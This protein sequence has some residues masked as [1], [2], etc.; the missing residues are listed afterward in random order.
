MDYQIQCKINFIIFI[1]CLT[2]TSF[3]QTP[4]LDKSYDNLKWND[5]VVRVEQNFPVHF[6]Y[7][8]DSVFNFKIQINAP[9]E[10]LDIVLENNLSNK[11]M[12]V[13]KDKN[14]NIFITQNSPISFKL[15]SSFFNSQELKSNVKDSIITKNETQYL[16]TKNEIGTSIIYVGTAKNG[17]YKTEATMSGYVTNK[18]NGT[19]V[20]GAIL[21]IEELKTGTTTDA[22][23][24]Y[25]IK[26]K[27]G[28]YSLKVYGSENKEK[29]Y[30]LEVFSDAKVN[31]ALD[32]KLNALNEVVVFSEGNN[33]IARSLIGYEKLTTKS[34]KNIPKMMG[35]VDIVKTT[36]LLPGVQSV[37]EGTA[38]FNVRG[39]PADQNIFYLNQVPVYN[40]SHLLG[41]FSAFTPNAISEL[42]LYKSSFPAQFGGHLSSIFDLTIKQGDLK[43]FN[44]QAGI[45]PVTANVLVEG[46]FKKE[47]SSYLIGL[48]STYSD[49]VLNFINVPA[50]KDSRGG[51]N[52]AITNF[53]VPI[54]NK[55]RLNFSTYYSSDNIKLASL[56][57]YDYQ[58][59]GASIKWNHFVKQKH[60]L[61]FSTVY[62]DYS[63]NERNSSVDNANYKLNYDLQHIEAKVNFRYIPTEKHTI[64]IGAN[65]ILY[66][67]NQGRYAPL[68]SQSLIVPITLGREQ[69]VE[70]GVYINDEWKITPL[71]SFTAGLR[72]NLYK[73][74]G[75]KTTYA[76]KPG[77]PLEIDNIID[78]VKHAK[79]A[80]IKSYHAPDLRLSSRYFI[81]EFI[82][83][84]AGFNQVHQYIFML[85]NTIALS[86]TDKWKLADNY[87][88][89]MSGEQYS[90]GFFSELKK[91]MY[92]FS[93]EVYYKNIHHL[94]EY[95][96]GANLIVNPVPETD[97]LQGNLKSYGIE[98]MLKKL[99]GNFNGW[100][101][102]TYSK[103]NVLVNGARPEEKIN[104]GNPYAA[105][106]DKPHA[107]NIVGNYKLSRRFNVSANV[108]YATGRPITYPTAIYYQ[109]NI[110]IIHYSKRNEYRMPDYF[111]I[112]LSINMEGNLKSKKFAHSSW[113]FS[114]YNLLGRNNPYSIYFKQEGNLIN[115]YQ[116]SIFGSPILSFS[117][118]IKL[119]SYEN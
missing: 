76:Y 88:K 96:D 62:S 2:A 85:T 34:V 84:K 40:T 19:K 113:S 38:G 97:V 12:Y 74:L 13:T 68:N 81:N 73:Y 35:E 50:I 52:D 43:K 32:E 87:I 60:N 10:S 78:T 118:N 114:V 59:V 102:Y 36:L 7:S 11:P 90:A 14:G 22:G 91:E 5:F 49:W 17:A 26:L 3:A 28:N 100:I 9:T 56:T 117:Y 93:T 16:K 15:P 21:Y 45:S 107:F 57:A 92:E 79:N 111:R 63:Y 67:L 51:F 20:I 42:A 46:P 37:G 54:N 29:K 75:P 39:S 71:L 112:D 30:N 33:N 48:R 31:F 64:D 47:K 83:L 106:Y 94:V 99:K 116:L 108:V 25:S 66:L 6:Y 115:G 69:G 4:I 23:G 101:N 53:S 41:F 104:F 27:K 103:A 55:N 119:G 89:P 72:Y 77:E 8:S 70:S 105:N 80:Q 58:N 95:K 24:F 86:P 109:N 1:C 98:F 65:S 82:S 61:E 110:P 18:S 44:F